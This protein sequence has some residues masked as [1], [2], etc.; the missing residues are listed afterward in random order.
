MK[1]PTN[2]GVREFLDMVGYYRKFICRFADAARPMTKL[3]R[4]R[5]NLYGLKTIK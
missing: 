4:N 5:L 1:P 3:T 2:Q